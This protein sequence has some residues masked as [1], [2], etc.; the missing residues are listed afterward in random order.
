MMLR[1]KLLTSA[2]I[3]KYLA[4]AMNGG[5]NVLWVEIALKFVGQCL[6]DNLAATYEFNR[7]FD[8]VSRMKPSPDPNFM[9]QLQKWLQDLRALAQ[10]KEEQKLSAAN[11]N[12]GG[13][14]S[15]PPSN[16]QNV[17]TSNANISGNIATGNNPG[18]PNAAVTSRETVTFLL[19]SWMRISLSMPNDQVFGQYLQLMHQ[20]GVVKTE[21]AADRFF[22][23]ATEICVEACLK[24]VGN[25]GNN[26]DADGNLP[27]L[28][29]NV[30]DA[31]SKLF[32]LLIRLAD[33]EASDVSVRVNLLNRILNAIAKAL[34][35]DHETKKN[36]QARAMSG[37]VQAPPFDQRPY[38]RLF[39]NLM[40]DLGSPDGK[41]EVNVQL[42]PS[43]T[44][45]FSV[46]HVLQPFA[47]PGFAFAYLQLISHRCFLPNLMLSPNQKGWQLMHKLLLNQLVFLQPFLKAGKLNDAIRKMYKG[48]LR[49]FLVLLHD[50][51]EFLCD[52]H[53]TLT[54]YIPSTC[55]QLRNLVLSAFPRSMRLPDPFTPN[56]NVD[57]LPE[58]TQ[59]PRMITDYLGLVFDR[60]VAYNNCKDQLTTIL[61]N[62]STSPTDIEPFAAHVLSLMDPSHSSGIQNIPLITAFVVQTGM[63]VN[64]NAPFSQQSG[65]QSSDNNSNPHQLTAFL[66][67][68]QLIKIATP[69]GR[70]YILNAIANQLRYPNLHTHYFSCL[71]LGLFMEC[72]E[73]V[74]CEQI[75]RVLLE[76]LI[77]HRPHPWGLLVTFIE[78]IKNPNYNFWRRPFTRCAPEIEKV[79]ESVARSC[80]GQHP[81]GP[82]G[83]IDNTGSGIP[84]SIS[85]RPDASDK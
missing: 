58:I 66:L 83:T 76:R 16:Q 8:T 52:F 7:V 48:T 79:L 31:L 26:D 15:G 35:D 42:F 82:G 78:L 12:S 1:A 65:A 80:I 9:R 23:M 39:A 73:E 30:L 56:L 19:D 59:A 17:N 63:L 53:L 51:P 36:V 85:P 29:Y 10:S 72:E 67:F 55:V 68:K 62:R 28:T 34:L 46:F 74:I 25:N 22:R 54:D 5:S 75:T 77:V 27:P 81:S 32:L 6:A 33:K 50:F 24:N 20:Y 40:A 14:L 2:D 21:E 71:L 38:H 44:T 4:A 47:V 49:V 13:P 60:D 57:H 70:Y 84:G 61:N 11:A 64:K 3:D 69:E 41:Q 43:L 18:Q 37:G 45:Y